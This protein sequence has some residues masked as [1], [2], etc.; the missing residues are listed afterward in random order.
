MVYPISKI[1][2]YPFCRIFIKKIFG[3]GNIPTN[4]NFIIVSNHENRID[5]L[6]I[7][8]PIL[9]KLNKKVH[10]LAQPKLWF[11]GEKICRQWAGCVPLFDSKQA[12]SEL[13]EHLLNN[14][15]VGI[16]PEGRYKGK[17]NKKYKTGVIRLTIE[18]KT[19]ILPIGIK[20]S[21]IPFTSTLNI[22]ELIY[23]KK[24]QKN[25]KKQI[26][27]LMKH[28]YALRNSRS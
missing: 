12:Y 17:K 21:Y 26:S 24:N 13:K 5:S 16:F 7:I 8:Y 6:Y 3:V 14:K 22:G 2:I 11:L 10:Y 15:I 23:L 28:I 27:D 9:K 25:I 4:S 19:P 1:W 18:T 20:S